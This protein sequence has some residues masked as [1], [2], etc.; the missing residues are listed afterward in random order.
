MI[1]LTAW[2]LFKGIYDSNTW[3]SLFDVVRPEIRGSI[4]GLMN[5]IGWLGGGGTAPIVI[6]IVSIHYGLGTAIAF[7]SAVYVAAAVFLLTAIIG[8]VHRDALRLAPN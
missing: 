8:F 6:G 3:A 1:A 2:G 7:A 5:M 4:A